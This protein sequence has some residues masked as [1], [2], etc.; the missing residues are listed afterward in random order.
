MF[1]SLLFEGRQ[2]VLFPVNF[3]QD[4]IAI[5]NNKEFAA[6]RLP[7]SRE[8]QKSHGSKDSNWNMNSCNP[9]G[10]GRA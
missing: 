2:L 7:F 10:V 6:T 8:A 1:F 9:C 4:K 5:P 3:H